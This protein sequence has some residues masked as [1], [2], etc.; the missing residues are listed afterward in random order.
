ML[1]Q[2]FTVGIALIAFAANSVLCRIALTGNQHQSAHIDPTSFTI[3]RLLSASV[4]LLILVCLLHKQSVKRVVSFHS[5]SDSKRIKSAITLF[6]YAAGFSYAYIF[7]DA[8]VGALVLFS[9]VQFSAMIIGIA[10]GQKI[11]V[12]NVLALIVALIGLVFLVNSQ[13]QIDAE[14]FSIWGVILMAIV[15]IAWAYYSILG[16]DASSPT[17]RTFVNFLLALPMSLLILPMYL[18]LEF[19]ISLTGALLAISSGAL[20]S[21]LGYVIWYRAVVNMNALQ[22]GV[23]QLTVPVLTVLGGVMFA[24]EVLTLDLVV[25]QILIL[26]SVA[27]II[28]SKSRT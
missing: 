5:L 20:A 11:T 15:G 24:N 28:M 16:S 9:M 26:G 4:L 18:L 25:A 21:A 3:L 19:E 23:V 7:L 1:S 14:D 8:G 2:I 22:A 27:S 13:Y 10:K 6:I 17:Q 12:L